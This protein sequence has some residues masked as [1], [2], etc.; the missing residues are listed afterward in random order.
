MRR[1]SLRS[2]LVSVML[3][4]LTSIL[5][6]QKHTAKLEKIRELTPPNCQRFANGTQTRASVSRFLNY[7]NTVAF[8]C[9]QGLLGHVVCEIS[10]LRFWQHSPSLL[11]L[12]AFA[13]ATLSLLALAAPL[14]AQTPSPNQQKS[15]ASRSGP[16]LCYSFCWLDFFLVTH[17]VELATRRFWIGAVANAG[18]LRCNAIAY[19]WITIL[20]AAL[21]WNGQRWRRGGQVLDIILLLSEK[22]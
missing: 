3:V 13:Q 11:G 1:M 5:K 15:L 8:N 12:V 16:V 19:L 21:G 10:C 7:Y 14:L 22:A 6:K 18:M 9:L 2:E 17:R 4:N 20:V